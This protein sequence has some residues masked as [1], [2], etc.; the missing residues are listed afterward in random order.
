MASGIDDIGTEPDAVAYLY[1]LEPQRF[2][3]S[4]DQLVKTL[5]AAGNRE[6][7][8]RIKALRKPSVI[9]GELNRVL[10]ASPED[11]DRLLAAVDALRTGHRSVLEGEPTDL[12]ALQ[13]AH[14]LV[15]AQMAERADRH[16]ERIRMLL[17]AAS[18]DTGC[19]DAL[20][21]ASFVAEPTPTVGFELLATATGSTSE[22][23]TVFP[24]TEARDRKRSTDGKGPTGKRSPARKPGA[25]RGARAARPGGPTGDGEGA[26]TDDRAA[27]LLSGAA[28]EHDKAEA[29]LTLAYRR[30]EAAVKRNAKA[31]ARVDELERRL[32]EAKSNLE[33]TGESLL[34]AKSAAER[35]EERLS[36]TA[37]ALREARRR[38]EEQ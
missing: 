38:G 20:R 4:R 13:T 27:A 2:V 7:A 3:A 24:L 10:R 37:D 16:R 6:L 18:L 21:E 26:A 31:T 32:R 11:L 22:P 8:N 36:A 23:A 30:V 5:R 35:A 12:A 25:G 1:G 9:A 15:A 14:R 28:A 19:H 33:E 29:A 17:E 34:A